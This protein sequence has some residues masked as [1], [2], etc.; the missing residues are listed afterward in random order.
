MQTKEYDLEYVIGYKRLSSR[1]L[2]QFN[3][4]DIKDLVGLVRDSEYNKEILADVI[5]GADAN[6]LATIMDDYKSRP[7]YSAFRGRIAEVMVFKDIMRKL[8]DGMNFFSNVALQYGK[9]MKSKTE[10]DGML[11]FYG[12]EKF[13]QLLKNMDEYDSVSVR[14]NDGLKKYC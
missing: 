10:L 1:M 3:N 9:N 14:M 4:K 11:T 6:A 13:V 12:P 2:E 5:R 7:E 8:P